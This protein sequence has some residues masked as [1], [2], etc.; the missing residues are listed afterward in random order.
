MYKKIVA[1]ITVV[2]I[3]LL[4][5]R[6]VLASQRYNDFSLI[7][8]GEKIQ[9]GIQ[10]RECFIKRNC[11]GLRNGLIVNE[12]GRSR[13]AYVLFEGILFQPPFVT[14]QFQHL[15]RIYFVGLLMVIPFTLIAIEF[16][17]TLLPLLL[18]LAVFVTNYSF[19]ENMIR[20]GTTEPYQVV[21]LAWF[22][23]LFLKFDQVRG[24][25]RYVYYF[26]MVLL[27]TIFF[28]FR[29]SS[30]AILPAVLLLA[31]LF[32]KNGGLKK[33]LIIFGIPTAVYIVQ[34]KILAGNYG[35]GALY[36]SNYN[37]NLKY[38]LENAKNYLLTFSISTFPFLELSLLISV[39]CLI[40]KKTRKIIFS[41]GILYWVFLSFCYLAIYFPW[42]YTLDRY[43]TISIFCLTI[44]VSLLINKIISIINRFSLVRK[45][46]CVFSAILLLILS[47][48]FFL[49]FSKNLIKTANYRDWFI[50]FSRFEADQVKAISKYRDGKVYI[51]LADK[52][53]NWE[54]IQE[55]PMHLRFFYE[56]K[57]QTEE[58]VEPIPKIGYLFSRNSLDP[59]VALDYLSKSQ[60]RLLESQK[61][62]VSQIDPLAF[63][64]LFKYRPLQALINPPL[65]KD[66]LSYY[67]EIRK[68]K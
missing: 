15:F 50:V 56:G 55:I 68:L 35:T 16:G 52:M 43:L 18:G 42:K 30:I 32:P 46:R 8:D 59:V 21:L 27:I 10:L 11:E 2:S 24:T 28:S 38:V 48:I 44:F 6:F 13:T 31:L 23:L 34:K 12:S 64:K 51:N 20:L 58:L 5:A 62:T 33:I 36:V 57:P 60:Y 7:D 39:A 22:S 14:P 9:W 63:E 41:K 45:N 37:F 26:I 54:V 17:V 66:N 49:G 1:L 29:E 65:M 19:S 61:Y 40:F 25:Y 3:Y 53:D 47:N 4:Y 67:W